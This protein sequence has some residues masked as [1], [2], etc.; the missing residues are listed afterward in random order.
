MYVPY[1]PY[2]YRRVN[3]QRLILYRRGN[4]IRVKI[5]DRRND[6]YDVELTINR[7]RILLNKVKISHSGLDKEGQ[8]I[9]DG[10]I[11]KLTKKIPI[12]K[13]YNEYSFTQVIPPIKRKKVMTPSF[14]NLLMFPDRLKFN[15]N[16]FSFRKQL[17]QEIIRE[18]RTGFRYSPIMMSYYEQ[19]IIEEGEDSHK[20]NVHI[21]RIKEDRVDFSGFTPLYEVIRALKSIYKENFSSPKDQLTFVKIV[22]NIILTSPEF[23]VSQQEFVL[24]YADIYFAQCFIPTKKHFPIWKQIVCVYEHKFV[25]ERDS[26]DYEIVD[27]TYTWIDK[28]SYG[29]TDFVE[30]DVIGMESHHKLPIDVIRLKIKDDDDQED[31]HQVNEEKIIPEGSGTIDP[32]LLIPLDLKTMTPEITSKS[33]QI[34]CK[35]N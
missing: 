31:N 16:I 21:E 27:E 7:E 25:H 24:G 11:K 29:T 12:Y 34:H 5:R 15:G 33:D 18:L 23:I 8:S 30:G 3:D 13:Y 6:Q 17:K 32:S 28:V 19:R 14:H 26:L 2:F 10:S 20:A 35:A 4:Q 1:G 9:I 22:K